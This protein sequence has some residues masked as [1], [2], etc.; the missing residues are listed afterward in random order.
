MESERG[1]VSKTCGF[2]GN[3]SEAFIRQATSAPLETKRPGTHCQLD[4]SL[5]YDRKYF[6]L[7]DIPPDYQTGHCLDK[8]HISDLA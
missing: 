8:R 6:R 3:Q 4:F 7:A 2:K 5:Q 1:R